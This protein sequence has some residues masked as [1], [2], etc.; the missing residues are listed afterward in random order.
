MVTLKPFASLPTI[1]TIESLRHSA[2]MSS[3]TNWIFFSTKNEH[4]SYPYQVKEIQINMVEQSLISAMWVSD[5]ALRKAGARI[6]LGVSEFGNKLS[7]MTINGQTAPIQ[8]FAVYATDSHSIV[9]Y[10]VIAISQCRHAE[11]LTTTSVL[12]LVR[13]TILK[14]GPVNND[15]PNLKQKTLQVL[16]MTALGL[17]SNEIA[18]VLHLTNRG[19][20]YHLSIAKQK[21]GATNKPNLIFEAKNLGWV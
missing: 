11:K 13:D 9:G 5:P 7:K 4:A 3:T 15:L 19:V 18:D 2:V 16:K 6:I 12:K 14:K 17:N 8:T 10:V 21:L 20:D 1:L